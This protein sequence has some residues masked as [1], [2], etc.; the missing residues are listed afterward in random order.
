[1]KLLLDAH[2]LIWS[3]DEPS[4]L[5]QEAPQLL[6]DV[7]NELFVGAGTIWEISIKM[8]LGKLGLSLP[9][10]QWTEQAIADLGAFCLPIDIRHAEAQMTLPRHHGDPFDRLLAAQA[11]VEDLVVISSDPI[12][13]RYG[14]AR[15][16]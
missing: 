13:D 8:G 9:F 15:R 5:G 11:Q 6:Q 7:S 14:V 12:F 16:W 3:V 4:K 1:M 2:A 10:K